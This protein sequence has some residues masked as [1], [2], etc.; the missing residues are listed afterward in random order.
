M[1]EMDKIWQLNIISRKMDYYKSWQ[2]AKVKMKSLDMKDY[3]F[4]RMQAK[5]SKAERTPWA[6]FVRLL[7]RTF[8]YWK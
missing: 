5:F 3:C 2:S 7:R 6:K 8:N 1:K 4:G